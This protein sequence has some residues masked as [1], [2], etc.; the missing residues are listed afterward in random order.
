MKGRNIAKRHLSGNAI[1][2][3]LS[4]ANHTAT[5]IPRILQAQISLIHLG[6]LLQRLFFNQLKKNSKDSKAEQLV[7]EEEGED[8]T[9]CKQGLLLERL[10]LKGS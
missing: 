6:K 2:P 8:E 9:R 5:S 3:Q 10:A 1:A 4:S 7:T